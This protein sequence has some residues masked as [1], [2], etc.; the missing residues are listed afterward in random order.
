[1]GIRSGKYLGSSRLNPTS[2]GLSE[3][4]ALMFP[5]ISGVRRRAV[6]SGCIHTKTDIDDDDHDDNIDCGED[7]SDGHQQRTLQSMGSD[8]AD[9]RIAHSSR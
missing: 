4:R 3:K 9:G 8:G 7:E 5:C 2:V 6:G 1:M